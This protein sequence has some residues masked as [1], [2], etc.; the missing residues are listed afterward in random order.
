MIRFE[1]VSKLYGDK[2]ALS[3]LNV[4]IENGEIFGLIGHNGAGKTTT[5]SILTS[6]ID[7]TYGEIY[8]DDLALSEHRD[9]IKKRIGYVPDS[10]IYS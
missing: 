8:V 6:I 9:D 4:T 7:A 3:D 1:H 2:E 5:I 10:Q